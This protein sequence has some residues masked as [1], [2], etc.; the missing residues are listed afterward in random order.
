MECLVDTSLLPCTVVI[1]WQFTHP[2]HTIRFEAGEPFCTILP[3]PK[4]SSARFSDNFTL[5][6]VQVDAAVEAYAHALQQMVGDPA[7]QA[8][9][10]RLGATPTTSTDEAGTSP[11][12]HDLDMLRWM[13]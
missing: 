2:N 5:A 6:V 13:G 12:W 4:P 10:L 11:I 9:F 7:L 8:L 1:H 3:Y